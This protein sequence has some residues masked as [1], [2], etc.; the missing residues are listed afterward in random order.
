MRVPLTQRNQHRFCLKQHTKEE[1]LE[2]PAPSS[3]SGQQKQSGPNRPGPEEGGCQGNRD[4][5]LTRGKRHLHINLGESV[6]YCYKVIK[7]RAGCLLK[8]RGAFVS[9]ESQPR[10]GFTELFKVKEKAVPWKVGTVGPG[11]ISHP[12]LVQVSRA[13]WPLGVLFSAC[14]LTPPHQPS[15]VASSPEQPAN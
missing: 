12:G 5:Q 3:L 8:L 9:G 11:T 14:T 1:A 4:S 10:T 13:N 2:E 6:L 15:L 7:L